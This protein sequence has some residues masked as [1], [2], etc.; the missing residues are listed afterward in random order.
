MKF[1]LCAYAH[2]DEF[3][4]CG[5]TRSIVNHRVWPLHSA[6]QEEDGEGPTPFP[7][8]VARGCAGQDGRAKASEVVGDVP[9]AP[10]GAALLGGKPGG[11]DARTA[12]PAKALQQPNAPIAS[13]SGRKNTFAFSTNLTSEL[14]AG[15]L[16]MWIGNSGRLQNGEP[17]N[18][19]AAA[20]GVVQTGI[21][22]AE[23][24]DVPAGFH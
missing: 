17:D 8:V 14:W 16:R 3:Q 1:L 19:S 6:A 10:V 22:G 15:H 2:H 7:A 4:S 20:Q 23:G 9:H 13:H 21:R 24:G 12:W 11:Q 18:L 5:R